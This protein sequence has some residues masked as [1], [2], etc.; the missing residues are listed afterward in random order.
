[1]RTR[2]PVRRPTCPLLKERAVRI[3]AVIAEDRVRVA[4]AS[5]FAGEAEVTLDEVRTPQRALA[6][7]DAGETFDVIV[8][9]ADTHPTGGLA[10]CREV[11]ARADM[12]RAMPPVVLLLARPQDR[13]LATWA[14]CDAHVAKPIDP[15]N[16]AA[17]VSAVAA[18]Q[19]V[20]AL[21][22]VGV[23]RPGPVEGEIA[24]EAGGNMAGT[25]LITSGP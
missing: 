20:P 6:R 25:Q 14:R 17:A 15:F 24:V 19:Q 12:G 23:P 11:K 2:P 8:A 18:G 7:L 10:L 13:Y 22:G 9:D 4:V 5:S 1:M 3:L 21:P 16:L